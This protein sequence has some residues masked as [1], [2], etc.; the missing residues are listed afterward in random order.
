MSLLQSCQCKL[1]YDKAKRLLGYEPCF[2]FAEGMGKT[3]GWM[4]FAGYP[5]RTRLNTASHLVPRHADG[6]SFTSRRD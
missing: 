2:S 4:E 3:I 1:P 6:P 5:V